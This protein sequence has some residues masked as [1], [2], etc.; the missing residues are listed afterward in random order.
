ML[1]TVEKS[2]HPLIEF[3]LFLIYNGL[4]ARAETGTTQSTGLRQA[5]TLFSTFNSDVA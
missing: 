3:Q 4:V 5:G 1:F 2:L